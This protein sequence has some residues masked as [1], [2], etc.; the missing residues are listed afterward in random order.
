MP[1][2]RCTTLRAHLG[3]LD[4]DASNL[5]VHAGEPGVNADVGV[6]D[7]HLSSIAS[8]D[9]SGAPFTAPLSMRI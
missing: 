1:R 6:V 7:V 8:N 5:G 9:L 2:P 3:H 4:D